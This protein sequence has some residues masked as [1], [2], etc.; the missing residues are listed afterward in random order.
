MLYIIRCWNYLNKKN[1]VIPENVQLELHDIQKC[2]MQH[3]DVPEIRTSTSQNLWHSRLIQR[4]YTQSFN[5]KI[6]VFSQGNFY[7]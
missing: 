2:T 7:A 6:R 5:K 1:F 3:V 4:D